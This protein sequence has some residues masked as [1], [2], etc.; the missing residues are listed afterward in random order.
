MV[1]VVSGLK[2]RKLEVVRVAENHL[3]VTYFTTLFGLNRQSFSHALG[4]TENVSEIR[5]F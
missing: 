5:Q 2:T 1:N 3:Q 4:A